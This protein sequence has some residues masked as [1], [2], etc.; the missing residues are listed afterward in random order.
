MFGKND[1]NMQ[2]QYRMQDE[3][4]ELNAELEYRKTLISGLEDYA[5]YIA[6]RYNIIDFGQFMTESKEERLVRER[7]EKIKMILKWEK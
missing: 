3:I 2:E 1:H 6:E 7:K 4:N 5:D